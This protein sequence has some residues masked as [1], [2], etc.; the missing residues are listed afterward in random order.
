MKPMLKR[1]II[2]VVLT[3]F[4]L[5]GPAWALE[6]LPLPRS[7]EENLQFGN[8]SLSV[9]MPSD[10]APITITAS[11]PGTKPVTLTLAN[12]Q[13]ARQF[14]PVISRTEMDPG[15]TT[16][17]FFISRYSG[18][19]H[20]CAQVWILDV[21]AGQWHVVDGGSWN[22]AEIVPE[23]A[24]GDG[25]DEIIHGDDRFL[26]KFSCYACAAPPKRV[27][28]L[29]EG[30]LA[31]VTSSPLYRPLLE[32]DLPNFQQGCAN[33]DNGACASFVAAASR[34]GRRSDAWQ[35]MLDHYDKTSDWGLSDCALYDS[36]GN[37]AAPVQYK[38][39]PDALTAFLDRI[40]DAQPG[41]R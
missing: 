18:G 6:K 35:F 33:H 3:A 14:P 23:D 24:D 27:F 4:G 17:E 40:N 5:S 20:C 30:A 13:N 29:V 32:K 39:Y 41:R 16:P 26:Y 12:D 10:N 22:G 25:E 34:L 1:A 28:K 7:G 15:N 8:A 19:A 11:A 9:T 2:A 38:S 36:G 37:C 21:I 31:D